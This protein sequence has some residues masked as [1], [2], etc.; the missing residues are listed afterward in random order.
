MLRPTSAALRARLALTAVLGVVLLLVAAC[1]GGKSTSEKA[2]ESSSAAAA[3]SSA[4]KNAELIKTAQTQ[5]AQYD[6]DAAIATLLADDSKEAKAELSKIQAAKAQAVAWPD[7][8]TI[9]H[10]FYHSLIVDPARAFNAGSEGVG[11]SQY[12]VTLSEFTKQLEQIYAN[13]WVLVHPE[14]IAAPGPD[15]KMTPTPIV[16][17]PGKKPFVLS[18]DDVSYYEYMAGKGFATN[19]VAKEDGRV[20]NTY[21]DA[22]GKTTEGSY[23]VMPIVDDFVRE[24]P[25]FAY[26]GDKGSIALTGYNGALGYRSSVKSYGDTPTTKDEQAKAKVVADA[27]KKLGWNFS[28]HSWGHINMTKAGIGW[29]TSD[30]QLWDAEIRPIVGDTPELIYPF[31][32]DIAG[33]EAYTTGNPKYAY[34]KGTEKFT[35]YFGVDGTSPAWVQIGPEYVRQARINV[36]G[37]SLQRVLDGKKSGLTQF[38]DAKS[39]IDPLRPMPVP[40]GGGP[41]AGGN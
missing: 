22:A 7:N 17:P 26:R 15:G 11:F 33:V 28:S 16:L 13:G 20:V 5:A 2:S 10:I 41:K 30:S 3:S 19:L 36:D 24:H 1:T 4:A 21:T 8:T 37:L 35:Y 27:L 34:L 25:D 29:I 12:M 38:F 9:P 6:Y 18:I 23:D 39:T 32:A 40:S 31:G 14:R